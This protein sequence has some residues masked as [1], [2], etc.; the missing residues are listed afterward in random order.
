MSTLL[1]EIQFSEIVLDGEE[2]H[3]RGWF[4]SRYDKRLWTSHFEN[5]GALALVD[6][7]ATLLGLTK[8]D[9]Q[10][11]ALISEVHFATTEGDSSDFFIH[12]VP[13]TAASLSDLTPSHWE[14]YLLG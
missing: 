8:T 12:L 9:E 11:R 1:G 13:E 2:P 10:M 6:A 14:S 4:I 5:W 3:I 7:Y